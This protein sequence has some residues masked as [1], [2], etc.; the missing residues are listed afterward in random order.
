M[1]D[2]GSVGGSPGI[3]KVVLSCGDKPL[4]T[5]SELEAE[6]AALVEIELVFVRLRCVEDLDIRVL[7][8]HSKPVSSGAV[9]QTEYLAAKVMLLKLSALPQVPG[10]HGVVQA[11]GPQLG[12]IS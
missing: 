10:P 7:H 1:E 3:E 8:T 9:S 2:G 12:A 4:A 6:D 5:I 11:P